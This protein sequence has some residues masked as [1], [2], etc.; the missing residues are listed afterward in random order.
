[1]IFRKPKYS[2][3]DTPVDRIQNLV[4]GIPA[5]KMSILDVTADGKT[6]VVLC[7]DTRM[8]SI[9]KVVLEK[10][11][12]GDVEVFN[13]AELMTGSS[14]SVRDNDNPSQKHGSRLLN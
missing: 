4:A 10:H 13:A 14:G 9:V 6:L 12:L 2:L 5:F 11:W 1:M 7:T 3:P 8:N